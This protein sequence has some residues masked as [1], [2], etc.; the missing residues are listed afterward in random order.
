MSKQYF[1]KLNYTLANEDTALEYALVKEKRPRRVLSVCG[2]G[3]RSLPLLGGT[4]E[5]LVC[6][7]LSGQQLLL[8]RHKRAAIEALSHEEYLMYWG[9][10]PFRTQE[11]REWR[12]ETFRRLEVDSS[13]REYFEHLYESVEWQGLI[14]EG[15][16]EKTFTGVPKL[17][18][19]LFGDKYDTIFDFTDMK[20]QTEYFDKEL[21]N[22]RWTLLPRLVLRAFGN[23]AFFN[24]FLYKGHFVKKNVPETHFEYYR[25]AYRRLFYQG[26]CRENF[27]LQLSFLGQLR[28]AE[29]NTLEARP[30][31]FNEM[32]DCLKRVQVGFANADLLTLAEESEKKF[33]FVSLSDVPS[34]FSA[35]QDRIYL[36]RLAKGL[37]PGALVVVRCYLRVPENTDLSG[38]VDV[39]SKYS[40]LV[41]AEKTQI[42]YTFIYEYQG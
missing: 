1:S 6:A 11:N 31:V 23:A 12:K 34:Y 22:A 2:S 41:G 9:F 38:Y 17:L 33:D 28:F 8:T 29:A 19:R 14:Y 5:E 24:A 13:T 35:H 3:G 7:D 30:E 26:L 40:E 25:Q 39:T 16:W 37:S 32:K 21:Q 42:Y 4:Q 10:P 18:R 20:S 27:F 15:K 36:Q